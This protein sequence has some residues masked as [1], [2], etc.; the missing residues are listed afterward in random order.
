MTVENMPES[1]TPP[2]PSRIM[3]SK[4]RRIVFGKEIASDGSGRCW[5]CAGEPR[6]VPSIGLSAVANATGE[7]RIVPARAARH[8]EPIKIDWR[9]GRR[10]TD[11]PRAAPQVTSPQPVRRSSGRGGRKR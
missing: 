10:I 4:C 11:E 2:T 7:F 3:C 5:Q 8:E 9:T 6:P 1:S